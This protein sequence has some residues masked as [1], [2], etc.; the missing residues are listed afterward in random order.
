MKEDKEKY[1]PPRAPTILPIS[2]LRFDHYEIPPYQRPYKWDTN[3]VNQ[4]IN[5]I[6]YFKDKNDYRLGTLV[7]YTMNSK[8]PNSNREI[9]D[10]QQRIITLVLLLY[11]LM[12]DDKYAKYFNEDF[13]KY[14]INFLEKKQFH[15]SI[16]RE[17][18]L[19]N[20]RA[21][22]QRLS[23]FDKK[24]VKFLLEKCKFVIITLHDISEAFQFF[25]SQNAR[26]K[27]LFPHDL[28]KAFHLR[29]I[30]NR[31]E[32]DRINIDKWE[33]NTV[34]LE[35]LFLM[36]FRVKSW[37]KQKEGRYFTS[38][39]IREFKGLD[40]IDNGL[41]CQKIYT[42]AQCYREL[43]NQHVSRR[44]DKNNMDFPHQIEQMVVNGSLFF[45][46]VIY[47]QNMLKQLKTIQEKAKPEVMKAIDNFK[48]GRGNEYIRFLFDS[49]CFFYYDKFGDKNIGK[50]IEKI[51]AWAYGARLKSYSIKLA[52]ID[53]LARGD[54]S[55]FTILHHA[56]KPDDIINWYIPAFTEREI[57]ENQ[58][59]NKT[60]I[61]L[62]KDLHYV[63]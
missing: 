1:V 53:N 30:P 51:F 43:Y 27:E 47:Y 39:H 37:I 8:E 26:G 6:L 60:A 44:V 7:L 48:S 41:P 29:A 38:K 19:A 17:N 52:S 50:V 58:N 15:D 10:G 4:L 5:D 14:I 62:L 59:Y 46:M 13:K 54:E 3:N 63:E 57:S 18:I 24:I 42:I 55:F 61:D 45:D 23:E 32:N 40:A 31:D 28:L 20:M 34:A 9:V 56:I 22:K 36:L 33:E 12:K 49:A 11:L 35:S 21:I 16:S 2:Q 25:D